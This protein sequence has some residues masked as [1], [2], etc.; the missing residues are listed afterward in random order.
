MSKHS[1]HLIKTLTSKPSRLSGIRSNPFLEQSIFRNPTAG[2]RHTQVANTSGHGTIGVDFTKQTV[3]H[4][5]IVIK[6][7][8]TVE[9]I[10]I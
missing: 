9:F 10:L 8:N 4:N 5:R 6:H 1:L 2:I 3:V 7:H